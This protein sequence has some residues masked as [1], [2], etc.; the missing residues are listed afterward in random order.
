M[1]RLRDKPAVDELSGFMS[2]F[3]ATGSRLGRRKNTETEEVKVGPSIHG[4]F[5]EFE[6][7]HMALGETVVPNR[8]EGKPNGR[9]VALEGSSKGL[10]LRNR[11]IE[12]S[13]KP[14]VEVLGAMLPEHVLKLTA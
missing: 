1:G 8:R 13:L 11:G 14:R 2:N 7:I 10:Q 6:A 3:R 4:A 9:L 5:N 12:T